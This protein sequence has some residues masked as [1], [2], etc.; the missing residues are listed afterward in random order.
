MDIAEDDLNNTKDFLNTIQRLV[1]FNINSDLI[2]GNS[3]GRGISIPLPLL[4]ADFNFF[5]QLVSPV[6]LNIPGME[7]FNLYLNIYI[8]SNLNFFFRRHSKGRTKINSIRL[9]LGFKP[10]DSR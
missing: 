9:K 8:Y 10:I 6:P 4:D 5:Q 7:F 3:E 2:I 1:G